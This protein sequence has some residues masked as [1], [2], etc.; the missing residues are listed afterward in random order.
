MLHSL[1]SVLYLGV[2]DLDYIIAV[3]AELFGARARVRSTIVQKIW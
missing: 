2:L 1:M 3:I